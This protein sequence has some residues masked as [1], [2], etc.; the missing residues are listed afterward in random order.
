MV[1][2]APLK[3]EENKNYYIELIVYSSKMVFFPKK[4]TRM[5]NKLEN[6]KFLITFFSIFLP[7]HHTTVLWLKVS[8]EFE[9]FR[10]FFSL[11][12][13][14]SF[15]KFSWKYRISFFFCYCDF[16]GKNLFWQKLQKITQKLC[17]GTFLQNCILGLD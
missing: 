2:A 12:V 7:P 1:L 13:L 16:F 6:S 15:Q 17:F 10:L 9:L 5:S 8:C 3:K 14:Q 4:I 11:F